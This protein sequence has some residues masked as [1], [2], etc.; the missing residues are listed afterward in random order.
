MNS[1]EIATFLTTV[2]LF[3][4]FEEEHLLK[5]AHLFESRNLSNDQK[6]FSEGDPGGDFYIIT[7]GKIHL[8]RRQK[9]E[10]RE[11]GNLST[12]EFFG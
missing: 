5:W 1:K 6:L 7:S 4:K 11:I 8:A 9:D 3:R 12:G 10:V 2:R